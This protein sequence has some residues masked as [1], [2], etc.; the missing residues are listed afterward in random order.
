M[1][2]IAPSYV[3]GFAFAALVSF[4]PALVRADLNEENLGPQEMPAATATPTPPATGA[5]TATPT[6]AAAETPALTPTPTMVETPAATPTPATLGAPALNA[7]PSPQA[8]PSSAGE[9]QA[10][11]TETGPASAATPQS[12]V[13]PAGLG[14]APTPEPAEPTPAVPA[15]DQPLDS[16]ISS[17]TTAE[18]AASLRLTET[19]RKAL[20]ANHL[21]DTELLLSR[22]V[23]I[24][25]T[26]P[27]AYFYLG[28]TSLL[29]RDYQQALTFFQRAELGL[30]SD[31]KWLAEA[32]GY[33][34]LA[35]E[36]DGDNSKAL[37]AYRRALDL[38]GGNL[39]AT[40]GFARLAPAEPAEQT[41]PTAGEAG[42]ASA[43]EVAP[44][45][46][47]STPPPEAPPSS[48]P[49]PPPTVP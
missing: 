49:P 18:R 11:S 13:T 17:A 45:P 36:E 22:A 28:R 3:A 8:G 2:A 41:V 39:T 27:Y 21:G 10:S 35:Y 42:A 12:G 46:P 9:A 24:D 31:P 38:D 19:A 37:L 1:N 48:P 29:K 33:E 34:G 40:V 43:G 4:A 7:S 25:P 20:Y 44:P 5:P 16:L 30:A 23:S 32:T 26:N 6:A 14:A 47:S 15:S